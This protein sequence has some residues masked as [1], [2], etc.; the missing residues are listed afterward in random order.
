MAD[1][2]GGTPWQV[3]AV[4]TILVA[5]IGAYP[6]LKNNPAPTMPEDEV[7]AVSP[8]FSDKV[9]TYYGQAYNIMHHSYGNWVF[10]ITNIDSTSGKVSAHIAA[11][12][13]LSGDGDLFGEINNNGYLD[14]SGT[15]MARNNE[16][17]FLYKGEVLGGFIDNNSIKGTFRCL[18]SPGNPLGTQEGTF[19]VRRAAGLS[20]T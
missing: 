1:D 5:L 7:T 19:E 15:M 3:W 18:P 12:N 2:N 4:V 11:S 17:E 16:Q 9:G 10:D 14:L 6:L 20:L 8:D 13:G